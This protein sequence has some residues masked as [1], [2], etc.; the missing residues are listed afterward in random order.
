MLEVVGDSDI[1]VSGALE[2]GDEGWLLEDGVE[3]GLV[4]AFYQYSISI[5]DRIEID[6]K[7]KFYIKILLN[8]ESKLYM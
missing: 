1:E 2:A 8:I 3:Q 5:W 7:T 6:I 4:Q